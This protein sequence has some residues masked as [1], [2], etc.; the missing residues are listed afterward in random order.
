[1]NCDNC[2]EFHATVTEAAECLEAYEAY[3]DYE[4]QM[5]AN[6]EYAA[7]MANERW[8]ENRGWEEAI[9]EREWED[10]RGVIQFEDAMRMA[11][12]AAARQA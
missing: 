11:E 4:G 2:R 8:F 6:A 5:E 10:A 1:M 12:E 7:E 3:L 9:A